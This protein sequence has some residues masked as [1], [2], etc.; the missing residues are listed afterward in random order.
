LLL[1]SFGLQEVVAIIFAMIFYQGKLILVLLAQL[2]DIIKGQIALSRLRQLTQD[3]ITRQPIRDTLYKS[4]KE[5]IKPFRT[6]TLQNIQFAYPTPPGVSGFS[7]GPINLTARAGEILFIIGGNGSG[8]TTL[9]HVL[10]GLYRPLSGTFSLDDRIVKMTDYRHYF[11]AVFNDV[12][13]FERL[14]G[15]DRV[16]EQQ[17]NRLLAQMDLAP[18][19]RYVD[20]RFSTLK[21]SAGQ[22]KRLALVV[23]L[24][25]DKPIYLF[26]EWA[27]D[28]APDFR[29]YFYQELLPALKAQGKTLIVVSHDERY[30]AVADR[31]IKME[32]GQI[33]EA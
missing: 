33:K 22:R 5:R 11:A 20:D 28:Q 2:P 9:M 25:E 15:L 8:K 1:P 32:Y 14:Y 16:D 3:Q 13:L 7:L 27:A 4:S 6:L 31:V 17:V 24:L 21:L 12:H 18:R 23:S 30:F 26:D 29:R 10:T 19:V